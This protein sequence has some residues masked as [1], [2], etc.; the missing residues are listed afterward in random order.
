MYQRRK[1]TY[2]KI[3]LLH[4]SK[5]FWY[6]IQHVKEIGTEAKV[7]PAIT[8]MQEA[9][10]W[11]TGIINTTIPSGLLH[12]VVFFYNGKNFFVWRHQAP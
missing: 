2:L 9:E 6:N 12:G 1:L 4:L 8:D 7:T 10:L 11:D 3:L 5:C